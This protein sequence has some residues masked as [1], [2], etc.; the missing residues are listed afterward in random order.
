FFKDQK[1]LKKLIPIVIFAIILT[2][3]LAILIH[4][5]ITSFK[6]T[7]N[8]ETQTSLSETAQ[9]TA[10]LIEERVRVN[11]KNLETTAVPLALM[12]DA[13]PDTISN[14][15]QQEIKRYGY[16]DMSVART[17][18]LS[19]TAN[20]NAFNIS[21]KETFLRALNG[22]SSI[23]DLIS[24]NF[25]NH[26]S[27]EYATPIF[28]DG[29]VKGVLLATYDLNTFQELLSVDTF[30][31]QGNVQIINKDGIVLAG[32]TNKD[33]FN[34][35]YTLR[36]SES[37][38]G[39]SAEDFIQ[40][41]HDKKSGILSYTAGG[42]STMMYYKPLNVQDWSILVS[43]PSRVISAKTNA[44]LLSLFLTGGIIALIVITLMTVL[45]LI[46]SLHQQNLEKLLYSDKITGG[47]SQ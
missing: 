45:L 38:N 36:Q 16:S 11:I 10:L 29:R 44:L 22:E 24:A 40:A 12:T 37:L 42:I 30:G 34:F 14:Y 23:S 15:L 21:T 31:G 46:Q 17:D 1:N 33:N 13:S 27:I 35:F 7:L 3:T 26:S 6:K 20:G 8:Q 41:V 32:T 43:V 18:G 28:S 39:M 47:A 4:L 9:Q 25:E 2:I 5:Y 19:F